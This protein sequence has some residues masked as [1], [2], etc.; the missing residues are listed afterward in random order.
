[1]DLTP[2]NTLAFCFLL[3]DEDLIYPTVFPAGPGSSDLLLPEGPE[4]P[5]GSKEIV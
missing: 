2:R 3:G 5:Y 4:K 1:M